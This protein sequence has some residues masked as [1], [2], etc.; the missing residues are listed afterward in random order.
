M[1]HH[2]YVCASSQRFAVTG[3][4]VAA[5]SV[6]GVVNESLDAKFPGESRGL[7]LAGV[8][9]KDLDI[10]NLGQFPHGHLQ[11]LFRVIRRHHDRNALSVDHGFSSCDTHST[12]PVIG[13][14][15]VRG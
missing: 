4:L 6:V 13:S 10:H 1:N 7:V 15:R 9:H 2:H 3:L 8:I 12:M 5:I 14:A 11:G